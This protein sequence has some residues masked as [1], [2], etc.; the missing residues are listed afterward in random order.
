V[1]KI[2]QTFEGKTNLFLF[3]HNDDE[4]F[5]LPL[6]K[7]AEEYSDQTICIFLTSPQSSLLAQKRRSESDATLSMFNNVSLIDNLSMKSLDGFLVR[8]LT[9]S[10]RLITKYFEDNGIVLDNCIF[11]ALEGGHQDHDAAHL[12]GA[13]LSL[14]LGL[15]GLEYLTYRSIGW[16]KLYSV[17]NPSKIFRKT[18]EIERIL[19]SVRE[20]LRFISKVKN[21]PSQKKSLALLFPFLVLHYLIHRKIEVVISHA[22]VREVTYKTTPL[23]IRRKNHDEIDFLNESRKFL[24]EINIKN[25]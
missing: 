13:S 21:Y 3:P 19:F 4:L 14:D 17:M 24:R 9:Y 1:S 2:R 23:Y 8:D 12:L 5:A 22:I 7:V 18:H 16:H 15:T 25:E 20:G 10:R 11:P 6:L